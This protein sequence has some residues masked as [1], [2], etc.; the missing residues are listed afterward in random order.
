MSE[1]NRDALIHQ[2]R[3]DPDPK[4]RLRACQRLA[5]TR[6]PAVIPLLRAA[7]INDD[8]E[9]VRETAGDAL[10][11]FKALHEG[12]TVRRLP[13]SDRALRRI[14][15]GLA[16][17][18]VVSLLANVSMQVLG[19]I[20][21]GDKESSVSL[22]GL[23]PTDRVE[24]VDHI[25]E[26]LTQGQA[27]VT[28]LKGEIKHYNDTGQ[29]ACPLSYQM[30]APVG[31]S[32]IDNYTYPDLRIVGAKLDAALPPT[33]TA[34]VLLNSACSDPTTQTEKVLQASAKLDQADGQLREVGDLLQH[35]V[36][37]PAPTLGP[38]ITPIPTRTFTPTPTDTPGP[39]TPTAASTAA[40]AAT[41]AA[42]PTG[43]PVQTVTPRATVTPAPTLPF[44]DLDYTQILR[45]LSQRYVVLGDLK[46]NYGTGMIDQWQKSTSAEGQTS[47]SFCTLTQWPEPFVL[48]DA[49]LAELNKPTVAD[50]QLEEAIRLQQEALD[51]AS[52]ARTLYERDCAALSLANSAQEG[53][54]LAEQAF[55]K[56]TQSQKITGEIR[57][58]PKR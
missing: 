20:K 26:K 55:D 19:S 44:P 51:L 5:A 14:G 45:D 23:T 6:D 56:L 12:K 57:A 21:D 9:R 37:N 18:L 50:S 46:N 8:D 34:L 17:L 15:A 28:S 35:A 49:Q 7:Y 33:Q 58:R 31:L 36:S 53:I 29:V 25:Q 24:L 54:A 16:I 22:E 2:L 10:A 3:D 1:S 32:L 41:E 4:V 27:L 38:T 43:S 52:Q 30:P 40:G 39:I 48:T 11:I 13:V 42:G 47:S